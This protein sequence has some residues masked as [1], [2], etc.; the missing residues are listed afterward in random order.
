M[1]EHRLGRFQPGLW[2]NAASEG[3]LRAVLDEADTRGRKNKFIDIL[4]KQQLAQALA[5]RGNHIVLDFGSGVGRIS[6]WLAP[7]CQKIIAIDVTPGMIETAKRCNA[8]SNVTYELYDGQNIPAEE[9]YFDRIVSVYVLQHIV[10]AQDFVRVLK[11]FSRVLKKGGRACLIE[12]VSVTQAHET[13]TPDDFNLRRAPQE[14]INA[15][16]EKGFSCQEWRLI[17]TLLTF[18]WLEHRLFPLFLLPVI[19][20]AEARISRNRS[21]EHLAYADCLF[22]FIKNAE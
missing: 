10:E 13:G 2:E 18:T 6:S 14:Y 3:G 8:R 5:L 16:S 11:E 20:K 17:R 7:H 4:H 12:Q 19:A 1:T 9:E 15:F 22:T 21:L